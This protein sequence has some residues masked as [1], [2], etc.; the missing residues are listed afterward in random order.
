M[1]DVTTDKA[2]LVCLA[3]IV[4][5]DNTAQVGSTIDLKDYLGADFVVQTG[6]LAD[7]DATFSVKLFEG[8]ASNMSDEAEV[9]SGDLLLGTKTDFTFADDGAIQ[10]FGY[11]G[12]K[13]YCRI[14]ITP[15][16]NAGSA[17]L[18]AC[19]ILKKKKIGS[20]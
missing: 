7:V 16:N 6:I 15:S 1:L 20:L 12:N 2:V 9:T 4:V 19:A 3:P 14:K 11:R 13:R 8:N 17:P 5:S 10:H 18:S